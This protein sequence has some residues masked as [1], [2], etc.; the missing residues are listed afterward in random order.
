MLIK[1]KFQL[2]YDIFDF[3]RNMLSF[4]ENKVTMV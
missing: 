4:Y 2:Y 1:C 3:G